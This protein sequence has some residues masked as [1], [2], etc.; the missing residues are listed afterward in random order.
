MPLS[1]NR[2]LEAEKTGLESIVDE[3]EVP[4]NAEFT[5][6]TVGE[7]LRA[8]RE[9][10][11]LSLDDIAK[12][13]RIPM[14]H[15][16]S[17]EESKF[18]KMPGST[19]AIGFARSYAKAL[20]LD[21]AALVS[22]L[23]GEL[24]DSGHGAYHVPS[25]DYEPADPSSVPSRM[26]AW[27]AAI[28]GVLVVA[29]YF[30]W[31]SSMMNGPDAPVAVET[32]QVAESEQAP[33]VQPAPADTTAADPKGQ[34]VITATDNVWLKIYDADNKSLYQAE[35]KAGESFNVPQDAKDPKIVTGRPDMLKITVAGKAIPPLGDGSKTIADVGVSAA[36]LAARPNEVPASSA[37]P[38]RSNAAA[39]GSGT[40][41]A[42]AQT[43]PQ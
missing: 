1:S 41:N 40:P 29:G 39:A 9:Q 16:E 35:M 43:T 23:R 21:D 20:G 18:S 26:L 22:Q 33:T 28:I 36:A 15:L 11:K 34:V 13:T 4:E 19:Y 5:F 12:K 25:Q 2:P 42:A 7:Q 32:E 17:I 10:Q 37:N 14:R 8:A 30:I 3:T 24:S 27:T 38:G 31:R 6:H